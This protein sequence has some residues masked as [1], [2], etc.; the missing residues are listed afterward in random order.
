V[1]QVKARNHSST[2]FDFDFA[3]FG[4]FLQGARMSGGGERSQAAIVLPMSFMSTLRTSSLIGPTAAGVI[5]R[6]V[7]PRP[8]SASASS[9]RPP[10]S[11]HT[12]SCTGWPTVA[13]TTRRR[14]RRIAGLSQS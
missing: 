13:A 6:R 4:P 7:M 2:L 1:R 10:I 11:P 9:R 8:S 3:L 14:K 5:D 12:P